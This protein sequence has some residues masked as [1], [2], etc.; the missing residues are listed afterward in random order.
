MELRTRFSLKNENVQV[1]G[2]ILKHFAQ[3]SGVVG[4]FY[5]KK[6]R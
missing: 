4:I 3:I 6:A 2:D 5:G 1:V